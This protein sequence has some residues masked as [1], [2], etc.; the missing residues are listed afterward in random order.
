MTKMED[1]RKNISNDPADFLSGV[2]EDADVEEETTPALEMKGNPL[3]EEE[4]IQEDD[5]GND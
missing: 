3:E 5:T 4:K 1:N 2:D